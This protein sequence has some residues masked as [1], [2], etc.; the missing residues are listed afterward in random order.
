MVFSSYGF[1]LIFLPIA[2]AGFRA[3]IR[4]DRAAAAKAWL[5]A[6]SLVFYAQGSPRFVPVLLFTA[7]FNFAAGRLLLA[8]RG[9]A[10]KLVLAAAL[11][12]N[13][14]LLAYFKY[15]NFFLA[16]LN[17][18][19]GTSFRLADIA[20]PLGVSFFTFNII[21]FVADSFKGKAKARSF[22]DYMVFVTF[23]PHLIMGPIVKHG[24]IVGQIEGGRALKFSASDFCLALFLFAI[25]CAKK[26][27]LADPLIAYAS[28]YYAAPL[29]GGFL[30]AW[31]A[32]LSYALAYYFDFSGYGDMAIAL[33]LMFG[34]KLPLNFNSPYKARNFVD[35]WRRWNMTLSG[36]LNEYVFASVYRF[37]QR[38]G[39]LFIGVMATFAV[40][41]IWHGAG[42]NYIAWGG[43]NGIFVFAGML[44]ALRGLRLPAPIAHALTLAGVLATRV[45]FD[46]G[47][48]S[49]AASTF[50][51]ML[52]VR[53]LSGAASFAK[54]NAVTLALIAAGAAIVFLAKNSWELS[55]S[56]K[57]DAKHALWA[58]A[59]LAASLFFMT[60]VSSFLY[61]QF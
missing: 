38:A 49:G 1:I 19:G 53:A 30:E 20:L 21:S 59:L 47:S 40:S 42:W 32:T 10:K 51:S 13:I 4:F 2:L 44:M 34:V 28:G 55:A 11:A 22:C 46:S 23:F 14:G 35:F 17:R 12:E 48:M 36:F 56:F 60:D 26:T 39:R 16:N 25:G 7:V 54:A 27:L 33:A 58:A 5:I 18:F 50:R 3:L 29:A 37:G 43:V 57:P 61:F 45:L 8:A 9:A 41:G 6:A 52:D 31:T 24:D 15:T